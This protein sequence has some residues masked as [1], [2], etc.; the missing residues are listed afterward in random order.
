MKSQLL[1]GDILVNDIDHLLV[2][3]PAS[4]SAHASMKDV[5]EKM[6]EDL[7]T[8]QVYV[9][10]SEN[11]LVGTVRMHSVVEY[12]FPYDAILE[13]NKSLYSAY[14]PKM[15][16]KTAADLMISPAVR[17]TKETTLG[18]MAGLLMKEGISELP[19]VDEKEHLIGQ[20]NMYE[21]ITAYLSIEKSG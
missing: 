19:V 18:D 13:L 17:V 3:N 15:G 5:L 21:V 9:V 6:T 2:P 11:C 7:R 8:R 10:D 12:L 4:V 14:L 20:V 1:L 16:A